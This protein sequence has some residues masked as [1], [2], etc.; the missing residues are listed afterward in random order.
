MADGQRRPVVGGLDGGGSEIE[1]VAMTDTTV[2]GRDDLRLE[3]DRERAVRQS[4]DGQAT[5]D[6]DQETDA[7]RERRKGKT[8]PPQA[9]SGAP[10]RLPAKEMSSAERLGLMGGRRVGSLCSSP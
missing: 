10:G 8:E 1:A 6:G 3:V 9:G 5:S 4:Q 7:D 2:E